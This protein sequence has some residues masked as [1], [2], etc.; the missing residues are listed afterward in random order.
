MRRPFTVLKLRFLLVFAS[1]VSLIAVS[2]A[3]QTVA[4]MSTPTAP[5]ASSPTAI[6][7]AEESYNEAMT[8]RARTIKEFLR[9]DACLDPAAAQALLQSPRPSKPGSPVTTTTPENMGPALESP[10]I[11]SQQQASG[12]P[13]SQ[14]SHND[15]GQL[16]KET[17]VMILAGN[18]TGSGF[19][20]TPDLI[21]TNHHVIAED[22]DDT[23]GI[24]SA[25][26][27]TLLVGKVVS[28]T[29]GHRTGTADFAL[30][31]I[32]PFQS[33]TT[34]TITDQA[35]QLQQVVA[36]GYPG[37]FLSRDENFRRLVNG[38]ITAAPSIVFSQGSIMALS[39]D[40]GGMHTVGHS[41]EIS[42]GNSGGPLIDEC[43]RVV[44]VNTFAVV[45]GAQAK[46]ALSS[47]DLAAFLKKNGVIAR[48][49][50]DP[51]S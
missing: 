6:T 23:V 14:M 15:M 39:Q 9:G 51:C 49:S 30:I 16:L 41:A 45:D 3:A 24:T 31:R 18:G 28:T 20:V 7:T 42:S 50:N 35:Q 36:A 27:G 1:V 22:P 12:T 13:Q 47:A 44:G 46:Y 38:D 34:L 26:L 21:V 10:Q 25:S 8:K 40:I 17:T 48:V 37:L 4:P 5:P 32:S 2:S 11:T 43:G 33:P 19:F 29:R